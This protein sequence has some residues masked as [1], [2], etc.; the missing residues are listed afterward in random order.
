[1]L[2]TFVAELTGAPH[3]GQ[4]AITHI[5]EHFLELRRSNQ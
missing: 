5:Q 4:V 3:S 2:F 1:M